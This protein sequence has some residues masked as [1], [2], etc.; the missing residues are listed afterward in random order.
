MK[1]RSAFLYVASRAKVKTT[2]STMRL[3]DKCIVFITK[4]ESGVIVLQ[5]GNFKDCFESNETIAFSK[6]A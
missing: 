3:L 5:F 1:R 4:I 6:Y 2:K